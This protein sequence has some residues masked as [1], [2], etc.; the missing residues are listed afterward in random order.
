LYTGFGAIQ[1][2][3]NLSRYNS[4]NLFGFIT[5]ISSVNRMKV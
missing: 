1:V 3:R 5:H 2:Y 4:I